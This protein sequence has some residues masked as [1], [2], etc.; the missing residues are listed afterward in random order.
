MGISIAVGLVEINSS[1]PPGLRLDHLRTDYLDTGLS[2]IYNNTASMGLS[3]TLLE[4]KRLNVG[5]D[6]GFRF[7]VWG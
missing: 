4:Q 1:L 5:T 7:R 6:Q 3:Y 2:F